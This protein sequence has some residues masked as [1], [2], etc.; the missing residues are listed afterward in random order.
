VVESVTSGDLTHLTGWSSPWSGH[1]AVVIGLGQVGF[2]LADT[3]LELGVDVLVVAREADPDVLKI[4]NVLGVPVAVGGSAT[5]RVQAVIAHRPDFAVVSPGVTPE[6]PVLLALREAGVPVWSDLDFAWRVRDK[7]EPLA[8]WVLVMGSELADL[9]TRLLQAEGRQA[10]RVG[11]LAP[12]LLDALRDPNPYETLIIGVN[13]SSPQLWERFP[14]A[15]RRPLVTVSVEAE[16]SHESG[17]FFDGTTLACV[18]RRGVGSS[19]AQVQDADV[20]E[21]ARAIGIGM[22]SPG[23]SDLGLVEGILCD[24]AFLDDRQNQALEVSTIDELR[25]AG[26]KIPDDLPTILGAVAIARALDV[27]PAVIAGVLTLP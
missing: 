9:A 3:A 19:E 21:G 6:D 23:M 16:G 17:V 7:V 24:R 4:T 18:Y 13:P 5:D 11:F 2:A 22:D 26:W 14:E 1:R 25:E 12:P 10:Y 15:P 27:P 20:V 8:E